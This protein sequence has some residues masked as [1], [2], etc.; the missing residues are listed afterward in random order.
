MAAREE[1]RRRLMHEV[2]ATREQQLAMQ[3]AQRQAEQQQ[4]GAPAG[5][6]AL[7]WVAAAA[8]LQ[9]SVHCMLPRRETLRDCQQAGTPRRLQKCTL[10]KNLQAVQE[11]QRAEREAA[12]AARLAEEQRAKALKAEQLYKMELQ[13]ALPFFWRL[14]GC[15]IRALVS[16][17]FLRRRRHC[18]GSATD[19]TLPA[20]CS[21][22]G[23]DSLAAWKLRCPCP[24]HPWC[25]Q[26]Q[27][28]AKQMR[29]AAEA[30]Q[31]A[32][33]IRAARAQEAEYQARVA[34]A[35]KAQPPPSWH[36]LKKFDAA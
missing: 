6:W 27:I 20:V 33:L 16:T 25:L 9:G 21:C 22:G 12:E 26:A 19:P 15:S 10:S 11:R 8:G 23:S 31:E 36:G 4:V 28:Q 14:H 32:E 13:V 34:A 30:G 5:C 7:C 2:A 18:N 17:D 3:R 1:A 24:R 35:L 29:R